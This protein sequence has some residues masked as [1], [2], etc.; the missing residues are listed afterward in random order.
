M[1]VRNR[2]NSGEYVTVVPIGL[3]ITLQYGEVGQ[4]EKVFI[5]YEIEHENVSDKLLEKVL[6]LNTVPRK[7]PLQN[8]TTWVY[9]V[10]YTGEDNCTSG[11][12]PQ[13]TS[14]KFVDM[15]LDERCPFNFFAASMKTLAGK[16]QG[17]VQILQWLKM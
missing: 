15:Y 1:F 13:C 11:Q 4:I 2:L 7:V 10:L 14:R 12:L 3:P 5:G 16:F 17:A 9:G 6:E 8:G